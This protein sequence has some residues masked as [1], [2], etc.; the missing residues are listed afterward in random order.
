MPSEKEREL[1]HPVTCSEDVEDLCDCV[2]VCVWGGG[3]CGGGGRG[4]MSVG[5]QHLKTYQMYTMQSS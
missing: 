2:C 1:D 5:E 4:G 3:V